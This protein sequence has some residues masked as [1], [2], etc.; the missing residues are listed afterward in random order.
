MRNLNQK[1]S[2]INIRAQASQRALIDMAARLKNK[3]RSDFM[4]ESACNEAQDVLL[5]QC[6]FSIEEANHQKFMQLLES[7]IKDNYPL[8]DL[9]SKDSPWEE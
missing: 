2:S 6:L 1:D 4:L 5:D 8:K 3:S 9:L 7:P